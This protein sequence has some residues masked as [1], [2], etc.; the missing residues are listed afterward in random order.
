VYY[1]P[2]SA[3]LPGNNGA[4]WRTDAEFHN[5]ALTTATFTVELLVRNQ[6]NL[7]PASKSYT[8]A[9]GTALR[10]A[11]VLGTELPAT[12]AALRVT[13]TAGTVILTSRTFNAIAA[14]PFSLPE[15]ASFG[16]FVPG[17]PDSEAITSS[18]EG[19]LIQLGHRA[20]GDLDGFRTNIG[21]V[22]GGAGAIDMQVDLYRSDGTFL[23]SVTGA[24]VHLGGY[25]YKQIDKI[26]ER[27]VSASSII[28]DAYAIVK[29]VTPGGRF[30]AYAS[31]IDNHRS[32]DS[33]LVPAFRLT[34]TAPPPTATPTA[35]VTA[36]VAP[37]AT[38]TRTVTPTA[39][40]TSTA[41]P[42]VTPTATSTVTPAPSLNLLLFTPSG[43][44]NCLVC[45]YRNNSN[46]GPPSTEQLSTATSTVA[47]FALAN[48][49]PA[50]L[51]RTVKV[52]IYVDNAYLGSATYDFTSSPLGAGY[53]LPL[54]MSGLPITSAGQHT[55]TAVAN[56]DSAFAETTRSDNSCSFTGTWTPPLVFA[57]TQAES[58]AAPRRVEAASLRIVAAGEQQ[59]FGSVVGSRV[60]TAQALVAGSVLYLPTSAHGP[61]NNGANWRTDVEVHNPGLVQAAYT[62]ETLL[63]DTDNTSAA[64]QSFTLE[65][66]QSVRYTDIL[67]VV[68]GMSKAAAALRV[69]TTSGQILVTSRTYNQIGANPWSLPEGASF[70][71]FVPALPLEQAIT[72]G[73]QGRLIQLG[74]R[75]P[76]D[77]LDFR[78][79]IGFVNTTGQ[80]IDIVVDLYDA[81]G[82]KLGT[83]SG[84]TTQLRPYEYKQIDSIYSLVTGSPVSD[85]YAV[86]TTTT[87]GG[88][89]FAY[90][91]VIDN[92]RS[93]D[94]VCVPAQAYAPG[95]PPTPTP[96]PTVAVMSPADV[97]TQVMIALGKSGTGMIPSLE[98]TLHN[99]QSDGLDSFLTTAANQNP[100]I[101]TTVARGVH[102]DCGIGALDPDGTL[103]QGM[104]DFTYAN[105]TRSSSQVGFDYTLHSTNLT[106]NL[107]AFPLQ[108]LTGHVG[109]SFDVANHAQC[110]TTING[111]GSTPQGSA[112]ASGTVLIDTARCARYPVAG[113]VTITIGGKA[114]QVAFNSACDGTFSG[115]A[116]SIYCSPLLKKS[117]SCPVWVDPPSP[118]FLPAYVHTNWTGTSFQASYSF[119]IDDPVIQR[120]FK[121]D[122][123]IQG[124]LSADRTTLLSCQVSEHSKMTYPPDAYYCGVDPCTKESWRSYTLGNVQRGGGA[125][126]PY[127]FSTTTVASWSS[128]T[129]TTGRIDGPPADCMYDLT[130]ANV[131][132]VTLVLTPP[133]GS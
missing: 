61:G 92:H 129:V 103:W 16:Q 110:T 87:P 75:T 97:A 22:N 20:S 130:N 79:N 85:G 123:T 48:Q 1:F 112:T 109:C 113:T 86:V 57:P 12:A 101:A 95:P 120:Y 70:G 102:V 122:G 111:T 84:A 32:G 93:G 88:A 7:A 96:T 44:P 60:R 82:S 36:T 18:E 126:S 56:M 55:V 63:R 99:I 124:A 114:S 94:S 14:N 51:A 49:G 108:A 118:I 42:T 104:A 73:T 23:G 52:G 8:L 119:N 4:N 34:P 127:T 35:T 28:D 100:G 74:H 46:P 68:F 38:A 125:P 98:D 50:P 90:A 121:Q 47:M 64:V 27:V 11:D 25:E 33:V 66:G 19:R 13:V 83:V 53:Y 17:I 132:T 10:L 71:Q 65:P 62:I 81:S 77:L 2:T 80:T 43:W 117:A 31:V 21:M 58:A 30:F 9:A 6:E 115:G 67:A 3:H 15:G 91:S 39:T 131:A 59:P 72:Y 89:F 26:F 116:E 133:P 40:P 76:S 54:T 37:T 45:N 107:T 29:T 78:T 41:T 24:D 128:R 105:L 5:P 69:T 106:K